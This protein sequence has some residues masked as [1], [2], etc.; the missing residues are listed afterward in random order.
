MKRDAALQTGFDGFAFVLASN[1]IDSEEI[2]SIVFGQPASRRPKQVVDQ[3]FL[4]N[5]TVSHVY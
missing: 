5:F 2:S 1:N 3:V 4:V